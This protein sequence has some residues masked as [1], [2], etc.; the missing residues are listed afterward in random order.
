MRQPQKPFSVETRQNGRRK[1]RPQTMAPRDLF[2]GIDPGG[3][4][5]QSYDAALRAADVLFSGAPARQFEP[6]ALNTSVVDNGA[7][8]AAP[9]PQG[10]ILR[11]IEE[12]TV[13][14]PPP[15]LAPPVRRGRPPGSKNKTPRSP[16]ARAQCEHQPLVETYTT[17]DELVASLFS[18]DDVVEPV[19]VKKAVPITLP[20][21]G[22]RLRFAWIDKDL[23]PGERWKRR[24]PRVCW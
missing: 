11:A 17:A 16:V 19:I 3:S 5:T 2:V 22:A 9:R 7:T 12:P 18:A 1:P 21:G 24:L 23:G 10:R 13:E 20:S 15:V 6:P 8:S 14:A 4:R